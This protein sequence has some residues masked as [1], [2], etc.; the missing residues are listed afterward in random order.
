[1]GPQDR[2]SCR[3]PSPARPAAPP[4]GDRT[5]GEDIRAPQFHNM[6]DLRPP[7]FPDPSR[8]RA[9]LAKLRRLGRGCEPRTTGRGAPGCSLQAGVATGSPPEERP[10]L[11][12][13]S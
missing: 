7:G 6:W 4:G 12:P 8:A 9:R 13:R 11:L 5:N 10:G 1:M 3:V 2:S